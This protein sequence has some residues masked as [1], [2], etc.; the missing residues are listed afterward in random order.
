VTLA[1]RI[2]HEM[3]Q[4]TKS[5]E[6]D[7]LSALRMIRAAI[8]NRQIEKRASLSDGEVV[9]V[10]SSLVKKARESIDQFRL[11]KREDLAAKEEGELR[12]ILSFMPVQMNQDEIRG[13]LQTI[14]AELGAKGPKDLGAVMK[15]SMERLK[16]KAD[17]RVVNELAKE[18][19]SSQTT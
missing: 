2:Q 11:G 9:E 6:K 14:I 4:A 3:V 1:E 7:R 5:R 18:L 19:L 10:L 12:V 8:Q 17:G 13:Q 15:A 16:G